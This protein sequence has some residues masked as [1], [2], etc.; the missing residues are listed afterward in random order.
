MKKLKKMNRQLRRMVILQNQR[1][2]RLDCR[3]QRIKKRAELRIAVLKNS[4][5]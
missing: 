3:E 5:Q 1:Y 2:Y 4:K